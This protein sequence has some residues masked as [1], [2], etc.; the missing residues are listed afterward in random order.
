[1]AGNDALPGGIAEMSQEQREA[2]IAEA[3]HNATFQNR[4]GTE[5]T[6]GEQE[7]MRRLTEGL[8]Q[9]VDPL[10]GQER[11]TLLTPEELEPDKPEHGA[12]IGGLLR[13]RLA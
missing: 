13:R 9:F 12:S 3:Q 8:Q 1:M 10:P 7:E 5:F 11:P 4:T 6:E 2:L